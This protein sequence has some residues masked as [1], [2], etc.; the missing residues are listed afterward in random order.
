MNNYLFRCG[1]FDFA[2]YLIDEHKADPN[3][4]D[5]F[6]RTPLLWACQYAKYVNAYYKGVHNLLISLSLVFSFS[7]DIRVAMLT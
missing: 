5:S 7:H 2:M 4:K 6:G 1:E 3:C